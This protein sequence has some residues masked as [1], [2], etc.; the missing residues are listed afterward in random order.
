LSISALAYSLQFY[1]FILS[2][3]HSFIKFACDINQ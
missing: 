1:S 3:F 2:F